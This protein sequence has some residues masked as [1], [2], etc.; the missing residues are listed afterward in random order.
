[1]KNSATQGHRY[2]LFGTDVL[3]LESG[4]FVRVAKIDK[5]KPWPLTMEKK[6]Y[7]HFLEPMPMVYFAGQ[8]PT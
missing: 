1:M 6:V 7:A 8:V 3:A 2:D 5:S 4:E